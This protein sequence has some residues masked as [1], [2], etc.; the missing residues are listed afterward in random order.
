MLRP[1][2]DPKAA[3]PLTRWWRGFVLA[4]LR[5]ANEESRAYLASPA[6]RRADAKALTVLV[7]AAVVLT[8]QRY[9]CMTDELN[10]TFD[11]LTRLGLGPLADRARAYLGSSEETHQMQRLTWWAVGCFAA[12]FGLPA[13]LV[14][15]A[16]RERLADYGLKLR[17]AFADWWVYVAM[18]A[19][20][21]PLVLVASREPHFQQTY[22]FYRPPPGRLG[23]DFWRWEA[24]YALQFLGLEFFFRGFL[25]HGLKR[26]FGPYAIPVMTVPY[27]MLHFFKP[28][29][30]ALASIPAGLALGFMSLRTRS[31]ALGWL[32]H[33]TVAVSMDLASLW[34]QGFFG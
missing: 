25:V 21:G 33:V 3:G 20:V 15:L 29:P 7:A 16:F 10:Q 13:L 11:L 18:F 17:G 5:R 14:R 32:I 31:I 9:A 30:E 2:P 24:L 34:R 1:A 22:P 27:C 19:V 8:V 4:P 26:R 23:P 28:L 6:S 12:F